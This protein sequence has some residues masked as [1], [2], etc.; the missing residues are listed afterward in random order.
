M[1]APEGLTP[2]LKE[3][4]GNA[5]SYDGRPPGEYI[6]AVK[7]G[8]RTFY[9]YKHGQNYYYENDYDLE[10]RYKKKLKKRYE[11]QEKDIEQFVD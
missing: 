11:R 4:W 2:E 1:Q 5:W 8:N 6:G 3:A 10:M 9:Y 7:K